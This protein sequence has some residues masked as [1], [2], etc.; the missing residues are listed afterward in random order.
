MLNFKLEMELMESQDSWWL[1]FLVFVD[2]SHWDK[3]FRQHGYT[4]RKKKT[5]DLHSNHSFLTYSSWRWLAKH[6]DMPRRL[7][8]CSSIIGGD[9][10]TAYASEPWNSIGVPH[11]SSPLPSSF[12]LW[13][14]SFAISHKSTLI[15]DGGTTYMERNSHR[16]IGLSFRLVEREELIH[17]SG[18]PLYEY[19]GQIVNGSTIE[20]P[21]SDWGSCCFLML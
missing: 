21:M 14:R 13:S 1:L 17:G 18:R 6:E 2:I 3:K 12:S 8:K 4:F 5:I 15:F 16:F 19:L 9:D 20:E 11:Y 7:S 10:S